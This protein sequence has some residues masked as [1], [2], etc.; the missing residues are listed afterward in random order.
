IT[1]AGQAAHQELMLTLALCDKLLGTRGSFRVHGG[2]FG[3][4]AQ[5][6]VPLD[7]LEVFRRE[8]E[9]VLGAG[10]CHILTIRP[11]GGIKLTE[12]EQHG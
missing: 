9:S 12:G 6:F 3:G 1:P 10:S 5:A 11:A 4:A 8:I 7:L 2:G